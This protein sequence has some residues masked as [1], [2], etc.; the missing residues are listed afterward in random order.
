MRTRLA[1]SCLFLVWP[2]EKPARVAGFLFPERRPRGMVKSRHGQIR[3][4]R[5]FWAFTKLYIQLYIAGLDRGHFAPNLA[6]YSP[7]RFFMNHGYDGFRIN[8]AARKPS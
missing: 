5:W 6:P 3:L 1:A 4:W 7:R 8:A 2:P